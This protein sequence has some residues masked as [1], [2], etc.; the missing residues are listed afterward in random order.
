[1]RDRILT[2][3]MVLG[4]TFLAPALNMQPQ[5]AVAQTNTYY[6]EIPFS[7]GNVITA[8]EAGSPI[9]GLSPA[10]LAG[11]QLNCT[12]DS[13]TASL[14]VAIQRSLDG[15]TSWANLV[16]F[17]QLTATGAETKYYADVR[18][19]SAQM[20]G[21]RLRANFVVTGTGQYTCTLLGVF[22]G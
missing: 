15:G 11:F 1:M 5:D 17:T 22:E 21:D 9:S 19:A 14:D 7:V 10:S 3:A 18:A 2:L 13:G 16:T 6:R 4:L 20:I 8:T 12:E